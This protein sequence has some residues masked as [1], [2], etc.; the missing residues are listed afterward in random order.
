MLTTIYMPFSSIGVIVVK[1]KS[2]NGR[3]HEFDFHPMILGQ[4]IRTTVV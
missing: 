4:Q 1:P 3:E 2:T